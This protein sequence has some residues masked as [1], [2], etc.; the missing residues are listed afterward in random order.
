MKRFTITILLMIAAALLVT[1][2][3]VLKTAPPHT[4][5]MVGSVAVPNG[6]HVMEIHSGMSAMK[7]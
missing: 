1:L 5:E 4:V 6:S 7:A 2:M 3:V